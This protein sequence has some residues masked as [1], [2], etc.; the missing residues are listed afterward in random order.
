MA[1]CTRRRHGNQKALALGGLLRQLA[2]GVQEYS[3]VCFSVCKMYLFMSVRTKT[4][5]KRKLSAINL[6]VILKRHLTEPRI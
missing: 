4:E 6:N 5:N 2:G 3:N 1:F